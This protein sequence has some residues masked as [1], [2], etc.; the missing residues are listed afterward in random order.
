[1]K[2][3]SLRPGMGDALEVIKVISHPL[4]LSLLCALIDRGEMSAGDLVDSHR[5][6]GSQSQVSQY[7][8]QMRDLG[9]IAI[10]RDGHYIYYTLADT[11][12]K[13]LVKTLH[14]LYCRET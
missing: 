4:R 6:L 9:L 12:V 5:V 14:D 8:S 10:R 7:L 11:R 3:T 1:M 13:K 2:K